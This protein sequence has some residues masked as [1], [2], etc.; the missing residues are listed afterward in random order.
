M[1][2]LHELPPLYDDKGIDKLVA[3]FD[4]RATGRAFTQR[5]TRALL[6]TLRDLYETD[7]WSK[8]QK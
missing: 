8:A 2:E 3:I 4:P 7:R 6:C 1:K 5:E